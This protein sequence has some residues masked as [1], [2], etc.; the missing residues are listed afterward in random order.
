MAATTRSGPSAR[1]AAASR[2]ALSAPPLNA[3]ITEPRPRRSS[4]SAASRVVRRCSASQPGNVDEVVEHGVR[5]GVEQLLAGAAAGEHRD[6]GGAG[7]QGALDVV[8]VVADVDR[9]ALAAEHVGLA[10]PPH[11]ALEVV[12]VE[13]EVVDVQ[14]GVG[15]ELPGDDDD[16]A[17]VPAYVGDGLGGARAAAARRRSRGRGRAPGTGRP[18][19]RS[20]RP[21]ATAPASGRAAG[22][23]GRSSPP[24][25]TRRRAP[26]PAGVRTAPNPG[27][28]SIRVMSRSKPTTSGASVGVGCM[29]PSLGNPLIG[30]ELPATMAGL[31]RISSDEV[32]G[33]D[34]FRQR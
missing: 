34:G 3:T 2:N 32:H 29:R 24:R 23:G 11:L 33:A 5:A 6:A 8:D 25:R 27:V 22:R 31:C 16:P 19:G 4:S 12:E 9:H 17:A 14:A 26:R 1:T 21:V 28:V 13:P 10:D 15:G 18:P 30:D 7:G 20:A